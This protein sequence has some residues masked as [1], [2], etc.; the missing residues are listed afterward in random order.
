MS[1]ADSGGQSRRR[2]SDDNPSSILNVIGVLAKLLAAIALIAGAYIANSFQGKMTG[3]TLLSQREQSETQLRASMLNSLIEPIIGQ[4]RGKQ[5]HPN[6]ERLL[7]ELLALNF[8]DH[9]ELKPLMSDV[10]ERFAAGVPEGMTKQGVQDARESLR[11]VARRVA[12][13]QIASLVREEA[14]EKQSD[15]GCNVYLISVLTKSPQNKQ[16]GAC[17]LTGTFDKPF[18]L[19][20]PDKTYT[21]YVMVAKPDWKNEGFVTQISLV[22]NAPQ[23]SQNYQDVAYKFWLTWFDFPMTDNTM[24][25]DGNRFAFNLA[26]VDSQEQTAMLKLIW[27]PKNYYTPRERPLENAEYLKLIGKK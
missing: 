19:E 4:E 20:S 25:P 2:Q 7:V 24:L 11:S 1:G 14:T 26:A 10:D 9:F 22:S 17:Q 27:F 3:T 23:G 12:S 15:S 8:H 13:Q 6:R 5:I 21:A 16:E 18:Q